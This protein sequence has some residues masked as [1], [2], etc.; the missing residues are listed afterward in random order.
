MNNWF[1]RNSIHLIIVAILTAISFAYFFGPITQGKA[2]IQPDVQQ[3]QAMQKEINDVKAATGHAPLWTNQIFGG[4]PAYQIW[5]PFSSNITTHIVSFL[6]ATFPNPVDTVLLYLLGAYL[7]FSVLKLKPWLAAAGAVAFAL[8]SYNFIY[9]TAGHAN[10]AYA[11]AFFCPILAAIILTLRGKYL[12][13]ASLT[14]LFLSMEIRSNHVQMTYYLLLTVLIL[15]GIELYHAI[16]GKQLQAYLKSIGFLAIGTILA[17]VVNASILWTTYEYSQYTIRGK[18][19]LTQKGSDGPNHGLDKDYAYTWSQSVGECL[20]FLVPNAY[21]GG[22]STTVGDDSKAVKIL[23]DNGVDAGQANGFVS[24][25]LYYGN[26]PG[27]F[28]PWYFGASVFFLFVL[29]LLI[30]KNR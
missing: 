4:M 25:S 20:T 30:V 16:K 23:T 27:T 17:I 28:G 3:A 5:A 22:S 26:K 11:I 9:I 7:L 29:G 21:G 15:L 8:S 14:G 19:N 13:G 1:K 24:Q 2:L 10:Q 6:K 18:S 12:L